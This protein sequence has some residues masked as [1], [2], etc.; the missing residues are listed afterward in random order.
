[1]NKN[2]LIAG[3]FR[4]HREKLNYSQTGLIDDSSPVSVSSLCDFENGK[5]ALSEHQLKYLFNLI[6]INY[7]ELINTYSFEKEYHQILE[8][9]Y[10]GDL[11]QATLL[12]RRCISEH[13][14]QSLG[15]FL[16][17]FLEYVIKVVRKKELLNDDFIILNCRSLLDSEQKA[18]LK[19]CEGKF[20]KHDGRFNDAI[21]CFVDVQSMTY[22]NKIRAWA[23]YQL[24][25]VY[26]LCSN[27][28]EALSATLEAKKLYSD[29]LCL[30]RLIQ[31]NINLAILYMNTNSYN[32]AEETY[33][34]V[35]ESL[36]DFR[37]S[38]KLVTRCFNNLCWLYFKTNQYDKISELIDNELNELILSENTLFVLAWAYYKTE[39]VDECVKYCKEA[40]E[41]YKDREYP[42]VVFTYIE[43]AVKGKKTGQTPLLRKAITM[44]DYEHNKEID[45]LFTLELIDIYERRKNYENAYKYARKLLNR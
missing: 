41:K 25:M 42:Q 19:I 1:M 14:E 44:K 13:V 18:I 36:K 5:R 9:I 27:Y 22:N 32:K 21:T 26:I 4:Y 10:S 29:K 20:A 23:F 24:S 16:F 17:V 35:L 38:K 7:S 45:E 3:F 39:R 11:D 37:D 31:V 12:F 43:N 34:M 28:I 30:K 33:K 8:Y 15:L 40:R 6:D 2:N